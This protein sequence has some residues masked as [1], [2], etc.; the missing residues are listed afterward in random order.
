MLV[1]IAFNNA[2]IKRGFTF[3]GMPRWPVINL[4]ALIHGYS[5]LL[6]LE[7]AVSYRKLRIFQGNQISLNVY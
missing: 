7:I 3:E 5:C 4:V 6:L 2:M 1:G